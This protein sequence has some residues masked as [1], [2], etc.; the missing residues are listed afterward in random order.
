MHGVGEAANTPVLG[1]VPYPSIGSCAQSAC[2]RDA[3]TGTTICD[4]AGTYAD[5]L[6]SG[7]GQVKGFATIDH[8]ALINVEGTGMVRPIPATG[9]RSRLGLI[10]IRIDSYQVF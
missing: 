1:R 10:V 8:V 5:A 3:R 9:V 2:A 7:K 6:G 4:D